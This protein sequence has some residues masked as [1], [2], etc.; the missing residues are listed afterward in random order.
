M[1][2]ARTPMPS[3]S[4][5]DELEQIRSTLEEVPAPAPPTE[6]EAPA[7][8]AALELLRGELR[9]AEASATEAA[10]TLLQSEGASAEAM[11]AL[12]EAECDFEKSKLDTSWTQVLSA[13][14]GR[15]QAQFLLE[16]ARRRVADAG[17]VLENARSRL[18]EQEREL[19]RNAELERV[20]AEAA[21]MTVDAYYEALDPLVR[22]LVAAQLWSAKVLEKLQRLDTDWFSKATKLNDAGKGFGLLLS[23]YVQPEGMS[24]ARRIVGRVLREASDLLGL[25]PPAIAG[26]RY[27]TGPENNRDTEAIRNMA[28]AVAD[29][30]TT[31]AKA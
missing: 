22:E 4:L 12:A 14:R 21:A 28:R 23:A 2:R 3:A 30:T 27:G 5:T 29:E 20:K 10:R 11:R 26:L 16:R 17:Q 6:S 24:R 31:K 18:A 13:R 19:N 9:E 15:D 7:P 25:N 1:R 8:V